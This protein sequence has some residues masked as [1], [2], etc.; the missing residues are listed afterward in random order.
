MDVAPA[1]VDEVI[2]VHSV[3]ANDVGASL[4]VGVGINTGAGVDVGASVVVFF[5]H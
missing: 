5:L 1:V 4:V 3:V 2:V